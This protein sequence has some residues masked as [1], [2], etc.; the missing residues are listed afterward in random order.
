MPEMTT[1]PDGELDD[2]Y[3]PELDELPPRPRRKLLTPV[4]VGLLVVLFAAG[5]FIGGVEVQKGQDNGSGG[6]T[7]AS[8][9]LGSLASRLGS[10]SAGATSSSGAAGGGLRSLFGGGGA[11]AFGGAT[12]GTVSSIDGSTLYVTELTGNTVAVKTTPQTKVTKSESVGARAIHPGDSIVVRGIA[13]AKG[14]FTASAVTDSGNSASGGGS[15]GVSS[16]FGGGT[17]SPSSSSGSGLS[18]L[19]GR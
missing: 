7:G 11:G 17:S 19:F 2:A 13:G 4:T 5:G 15:G 14:T 3:Y 6:G 12:A 8:S 18:S 1:T 9:F 16:L 10:A